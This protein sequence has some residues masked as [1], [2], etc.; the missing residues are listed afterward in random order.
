M[1]RLQARDPQLEKV[2][3]ANK[4]VFEE[5]PLQGTEAKI[6]VDPSAQPKFVKARPV[7]YALNK[8]E[9]RVGARPTGTRGNYFSRGIQ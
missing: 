9:N 4:E 1:F 2:L 8:G 6:Y 5:G 3:E 7:P